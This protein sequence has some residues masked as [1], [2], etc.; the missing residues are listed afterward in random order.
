MAN[1][2]CYGDSHGN[3]VFG[4]HG[5][6]PVSGLRVSTVLYNQKIELNFLITMKCTCLLLKYPIFQS[7]VLCPQKTFCKINHIQSS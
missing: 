4:I 1:K 7:Q 5:H 6:I 2:F 3:E